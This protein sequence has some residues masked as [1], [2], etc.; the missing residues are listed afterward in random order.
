MKMYA[1]YLNERTGT[2][3][4]QLEHGFATFK[5]LDA[6]TY[7]L[8]DIYVEPEFRRKRIASELSQ[9][10]CEIA[11]ADGAKKLIGSVDISTNGVTESMKAILADGF[12]FSHAQGNGIY[13]V[14]DI[15]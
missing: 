13:F 9:R 1:D 4:L 2:S 6:D 7:Y 15:I 10:V 5:K 14:K 12:R 8:I 3:L 11:K